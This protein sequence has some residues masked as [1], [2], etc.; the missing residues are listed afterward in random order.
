MIEEL[1]SIFRSVF[2]DEGLV[3]NAATTAA[4]VEGW[5]SL[6]HIRLIVAIEKHFSLRFSAAEI[7]EVENVGQMLE[8]ILKKKNIL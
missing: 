2:D 3:I 5:D 8:L 4:D 1:N 7:S 6:T